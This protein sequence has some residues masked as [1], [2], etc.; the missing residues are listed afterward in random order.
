MSVHRD[1]ILTEVYNE[2]T[3]QDEKWGVQ[4]HPDG[5]SE[6]LAT[7]RDEYRATTDRNA[8]EGRVTYY[9]IL[10]EEVWE[11]MAEVDKAKLRTELIQVAAVTVAWV[12]KLDREAA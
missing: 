7:L 1:E 6:F 5:T 3:R 8:Q 12:E 10:M 4:N 11:A 9:D 2:R